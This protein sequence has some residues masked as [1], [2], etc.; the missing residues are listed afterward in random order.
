MSL[1]YTVHFQL[2]ILL[3][4]CAVN[5]FCAAPYFL[6]VLTQRCTAASMSNFVITFISFIFIFYINATVLVSKGVCILEHRDG[7]NSWTPAKLADLCIADPPIRQTLQ[8]PL[9]QSGPI[10]IHRLI[11]TAARKGGNSVIDR[12][13]CIYL[14]HVSWK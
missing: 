14:R 3:T 12:M 1:L 8:P 11:G 5:C 6:V 2:Y 10:T 4:S 9:R 13:G 7:L